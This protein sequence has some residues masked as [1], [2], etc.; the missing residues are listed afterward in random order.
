MFFTKHTLS[1]AHLGLCPWR[2]RFPAFAENKTKQVKK[3]NCFILLYNLGSE[4]YKTVKVFAFA[5]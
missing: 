4:S 3:N 1:S 5:I 2:I